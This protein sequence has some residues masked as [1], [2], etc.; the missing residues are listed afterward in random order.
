MTSIILQE[1]MVAHKQCQC[2]GICYFDTGH[3][4]F[5]V[6]EDTRLCKKIPKNQQAEDG[7]AAEIQYP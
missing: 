6:F 5:E 2:K 3:T 7:G 4:S 1:I